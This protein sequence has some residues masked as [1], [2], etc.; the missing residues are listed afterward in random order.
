MSQL[1]LEYRF[2]DQYVFLWQVWYIPSICFFVVVGVLPCPR[3]A[4]LLHPSPAAVSGASPHC[5][6]TA[7][8]GPKHPE[9][10]GPSNLKLETHPEDT[11]G[12]THKCG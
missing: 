7:G 10:A 11:L 3:R 12:H 1:F 9:P 4:R 5:A 8:S 6:G 2:I